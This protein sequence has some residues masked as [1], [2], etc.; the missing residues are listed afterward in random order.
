MDTSLVEQGA[1][2]DCAGTSNITLET[3]STTAQRVIKTA[4]KEVRPE[5]ATAAQQR[6]Q[7]REGA[8]AKD[9]MKIQ[10]QKKPRKKPGKGAL[11]YKVSAGTTKA[12]RPKC[13]RPGVQALMEIR[14]YQKDSILLIRKLPFQCL[15][16]E[17]TQ[18]FKTDAQFQYTALEALQEPS[19]AYLI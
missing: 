11:T 15:V 1:P 5:V 14:H 18:D 6:L 3:V 19:E 9:R 8:Q 2:L 13:F 7:V 17:I 4:S 10:K 12:G 16:R